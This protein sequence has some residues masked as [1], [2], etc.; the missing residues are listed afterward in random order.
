MIEV[1]ALPNSEDTTTDA[2]NRNML[3]LR[4]WA[5]AASEETP[6]TETTS[7]FEVFPILAITQNRIAEYTYCCR[8][9]QNPL[10]SL[11]Q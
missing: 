11:I 2:R 6:W 1:F 9:Y 3:V 4:R 5:F 10:S 7:N 8:L